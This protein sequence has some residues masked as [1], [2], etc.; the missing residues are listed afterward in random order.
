MKRKGFNELTY[1]FCTEPKLRFDT[2]LK[3][4]T[5]PSKRSFGGAD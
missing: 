1:Q 5:R 2:N 3:D 4:L